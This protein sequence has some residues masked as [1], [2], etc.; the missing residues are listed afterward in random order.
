MSAVGGLCK[1]KLGARDTIHINIYLAQIEGY[2]YI[3]ITM[4]SIYAEK[5]RR[6]KTGHNGAVG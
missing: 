3:T 4:V 1:T 5:S 6:S 2:S